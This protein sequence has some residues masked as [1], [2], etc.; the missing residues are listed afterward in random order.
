MLIGV[1]DIL[2]PGTVAPLDEEVTAADVIAGYRGL[3]LPAK[4]QGAATHFCT[5]LPFGGAAGATVMREETRQQ[6]NAWIRASDE[7][8]GFI[9]TGLAL[10]DPANPER[11]RPDF[12]SGDHLHPNAAGQREIASVVGRALQIIGVVELSARRE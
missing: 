2:Q 5:L 4:S 12:D 8:I 11:L 1:N 9:E 7:G 3:M 6:I 10:A